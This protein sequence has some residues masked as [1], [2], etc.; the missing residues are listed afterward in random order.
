MAMIMRMIIIY[1][2][3]VIMRNTCKWLD[4]SK[5][6][7]F[8]MWQR[9][10]GIASYLS[11]VVIREWMMNLS[12]IFTLEIWKRNTLESVT[13]RDIVIYRALVSV[14]SRILNFACK[15]TLDDEL[16]KENFKIIWKQCNMKARYSCD[17]C[18]SMWFSWP[19]MCTCRWSWPSN[20]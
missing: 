19:T 4:V 12:K 7:V 6:A 15:F 2:D 5:K 20:P 1:Q 10:Q 9:C 13:I 17:F 18:R 14:D 3:D 11:V 16:F 8:F